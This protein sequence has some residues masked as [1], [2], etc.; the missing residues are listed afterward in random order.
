M[1]SY[2]ADPKRARR[3]L[4]INAALM[5]VSSGVCAYSKRDSD[6]PMLYFVG[7]GVF[8]L[9]VVVAF[10]FG[11]RRQGRPL[12]LEL[13]PEALLIR[14]PGERRFQ[15]SAFEAAWF[16]PKPCMLCFRI[17]ETKERREIPLAGYADPVRGQILD[18]V[19]A[20]LGAR[21][22]SFFEQPIG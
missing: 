5:L 21:Y 6:D 17:Q 2:T 10:L 14:D 13:G 20:H 9:L 12:T 16:D 22:V 19:G 18:Q 3:R 8:A 15:W 1:T 7:M 4:Q 11:L